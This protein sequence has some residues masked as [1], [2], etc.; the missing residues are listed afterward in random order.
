[1]GTIL[2]PLSQPCEISGHWFKPMSCGSFHQ[3]IL[4]NSLKHFHRARTAEFPGRFGMVKSSAFGRWMLRWVPEP[5]LWPDNGIQTLPWGLVGPP[6]R[7]I[8]CKSGRHWRTGTSR[9][10]R[11]GVSDARGAKRLNG[12][13]N[14]LVR[15]TVRQPPNLSDS[16]HS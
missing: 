6:T 10:K 16:C 3:R 14:T 12:P 9:K 1:M 5:W 11:I 15:N 8:W 2:A 13:D 4:S 7:W